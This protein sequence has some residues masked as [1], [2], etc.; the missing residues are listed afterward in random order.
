MTD[1]ALVTACLLRA[2]L[3]AEQRTALQGYLRRLE[4][5]LPLS[6]SA[7]SMVRNIAVRARILEVPAPKKGTSLRSGGMYEDGIYSSKR[8]PGTDFAEQVLQHRPLAPPGRRA[9]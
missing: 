9:G 5:G 2:D 1:H 4:S 8:G 7:K 6:I 3:T